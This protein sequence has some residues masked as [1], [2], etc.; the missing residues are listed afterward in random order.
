MKF[1]WDARKAAENLKK[2]GV[3][4]EDAKKVFDDVK[5]VHFPDDSAPYG[6]ER[7]L[8]IGASGSELLFLVYVERR[9]V[10]R[11]IS[12]RPATKREKRVYADENSF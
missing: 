3:S 8:A 7:F 2:H 6:E 4:F 10:N 1:E 12:C 11:I 5:A 9:G